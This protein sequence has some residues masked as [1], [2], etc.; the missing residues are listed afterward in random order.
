[1]L[2]APDYANMQMGQMEQKLKQTKSKD[3]ESCKNME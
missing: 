3:K 2:H 1:M